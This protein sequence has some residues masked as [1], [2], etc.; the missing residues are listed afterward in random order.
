[1]FKDS[2]TFV[3]SSFPKHAS[4]KPSGMDWLGEVPERWK[5]E[6]LKNLF[7]ERKEVNNS[8]VNFYLSVTRDRGVIPYSE[9]GDIGNRTSDNPEKYKL[10]CPND[11]VINPMNVKIGSVGLSKYSGALST[12]YIVL[13][14][15]DSVIPGFAGYLFQSRSFQKQ[16]IRISYGIMELRESLKK[17]L[18]FAERVALPNLREQSG[19]VDFLDS[20][21]QEIEEAI[22]Q[23]QRTI[24]LL[25]E[26]KHSLIE[27][28]VT[29]GLDPSAP[30]K[31]SGEDWLG[32]VPEHWY[33]ISLRNVLTEV[34][35]KGFTE[36]P[37]LSITRELGIIERDV[38]DQKSNHNFIPPDLSGYKRIKKGNFGM[39]K[40]KAWQGSYGVFGLHRYRK[41]CIL[42]LLIKRRFGPLIFSLGCALK[43]L[44][45][46][47]GQIQ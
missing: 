46:R 3:S 28:A 44:C 26:Y 25:E 47:N 10:V 18:F 45:R 38:D 41:S 16:L 29:K 36:L 24:E 20:K 7:V 11:I 42:R 15:T 13:T 33:L 27:Q 34:S 8:G 12:I 31:D 40:M 39:N 2:T 21:T 43:G 5:I 17:V 22:K 23:K 9:K 19:V 37:L 4:Y 30:M 6:K 14:P 35:D 1:M 32:E